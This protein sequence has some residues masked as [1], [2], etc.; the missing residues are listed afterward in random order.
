MRF[1]VGY[2]DTHCAAGRMG[3]TFRRRLFPDL[4]GDFSGRSRSRR[5]KT[6][7]NNRILSGRKSLELDFMQSFSGFSLEFV[8]VF[9][10]KRKM[11]KED[12]PGSVRAG[13]DGSGDAA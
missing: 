8:P 11:E 3:N 1:V 7:C 5:C 9:A 13:R 2:M 6:V 4:Q 10:W 12:S